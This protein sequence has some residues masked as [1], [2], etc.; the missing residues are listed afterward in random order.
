MLT[1]RSLLDESSGL[2]L[3]LLAGESGLGRPITIHRIQKPGLALAGFVRQVHPE[4]VQVLGSTEI[5]YLQ[6]LSDDD[7][8]RSVEGFV[9]LNPACVVVTKGLDVPAVLMDVADRAGVPLLRT[10][11]VSSVA[12][13][14]IQKHLE[15]Q[16]A[17]T[18]SIHAVLLDVLGVGV[19]LLGKSGIG[20]S[21]AAL[22]LIM[23]GHR[24]VADD[25]VE[26]R[27]TSGDV[28]VGWASELIK[29]HMEVRGLGIINIKDMF[30]VA[31]VRD[32]KRIELVL[33]LMKW[34]QTES[35]DR[36]GLDEMVYP[37]LEVPVPLLRIPVSPGRNVSSLIEVAARN[38]LL[39]VR[40]HHSAR[41]FQERLDRALADARERRW[42]DDVE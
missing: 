39:Q 1:V 21:E 13:D 17:P 38:R 26:V 11:V 22:D 31:A 32:E 42:R 3:V 18:A 28:L 19:L 30:G 29:H 9:G 20:K 27:R 24:L 41:E 37:I 36:L 4:R 2:R 10:P 15:L 5:S 6:T 16:L 40:G 12:I 8:R 7:A 25:L 35:H 23:R 34:D 14:A 33:E